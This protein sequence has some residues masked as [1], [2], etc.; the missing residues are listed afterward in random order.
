MGG[1]ESVVIDLLG[2]VCRWAFP[3]TDTAN[4]LNIAFGTHQT[5][6]LYQGGALFDIT[7]SSGFTPGNIDGT[8]STGYGTGAYGVGLYGAP[9]VTDYFPLTWSGG[10]FGQ[11]LISSPRGQGAFQWSNNTASPAAIITNAPANITYLGIAPTRQVFAFG[12]NEEVSGIFNPSCIRHCS[13][14]DVTDWTTTSSSASTAREYILP[15]GGRIVGARLVGRSWLVWTNFGLFVGTYYG[16]IGKVWS[17]DRVPGNCGLLGPGAAII[18]GSTAFWTSPDRQFY[19]Y[20]LGGTVQPVACPIREDYATNLAASQGDKVVASSIA[21]FGEI[22]F[23]YPDARDGFENSRYIAVPVEGPDAGSW[24][25]G[26]QARTSM[27]DA[28]PSAYPVG[29]TYAGNIYYHEKGNSADG[30]ALSGLLRTAEM[31]LS[32]DVGYLLRKLFPDVADQVGPLM[33]TVYTRDFAQGDQTT[34]GPYTLTPGQDE[35]DFEPKPSGK[36]F[37]F[38]LEWSSSPANMRWGRTLLEVKPRG[39]R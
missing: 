15:G 2:G 39:R 12:C 4:N 30:A 27:V 16:Q 3:W 29:T 5:L 26:I 17:F 1:H 31:F 34:Y 6:E 37:S 14:A 23:D 19:S 22:R 13:I 20:T 21:E 11:T 28:G 38:L 7:P 24:Y 8:G 36:L 18:V 10:A 32:D 35:V 25:R 33:L 9:S